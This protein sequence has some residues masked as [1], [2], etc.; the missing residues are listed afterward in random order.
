MLPHLKERLSS[1]ID[2]GR[3]FR[4]KLFA[5]MGNDEI[6]G[7]TY[8]FTRSESFVRVCMIIDNVYYFFVIALMLAGFYVLF[9]R[10]AQSALFIVPLFAL[11]LTLAHMLVEVSSRYHY[12]LIPMFIIVA[13]F[14]AAEKSRFGGYYHDAE[15]VHSHSVL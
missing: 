4:S 13:A 14:T 10:G 11:G 9:R 8:R 2:F 12:S 7:Y 15:T 3:L 5:F 1:G 6:G